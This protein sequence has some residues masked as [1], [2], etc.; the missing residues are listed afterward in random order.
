MNK[1]GLNHSC[2]FVISWKFLYLHT[3]EAAKEGSQIIC[4]FEPIK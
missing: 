2:G 3:E 4:H 1:L